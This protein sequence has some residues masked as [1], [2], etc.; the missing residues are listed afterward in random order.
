MHR[1]SNAESILRRAAQIEAGRNDPL[2]TLTDDDLVEAGRAAGLSE[3]AIRQAIAEQ[4]FGPVNAGQPDDLRWTVTRRVPELADGQRA[5]LFSTIRSAAP[6]SAY[7]AYGFDKPVETFGNAQQ[8]TVNSGMSS[9]VWAKMRVGPAPDGKGDVWT[10]EHNAR[11]DVMGLS[12]LVV[13]LT[14][15][16]TVFGAMVA[17][18]TLDVSRLP[19][20]GAALLVTI[21]STLAVAPLRRSILT[22]RRRQFDALVTDLDRIAGAPQPWSSDA[23]ELPTPSAPLLVLDDASAADTPVA[24]DPATT[25]SAP[26]RTR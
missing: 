23:R 24:G 10:L 12:W 15:L 13:V 8:W 14:A 17:A 5:E 20:L 25:T 26:L 22:R 6:Y 9:G 7:S 16:L 3:E 18:K 11:T 19:L 1:S 4:R 21:A 2:A